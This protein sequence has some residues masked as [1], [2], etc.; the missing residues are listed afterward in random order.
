MREGAETVVECV[1]A[2][3]TSKRWCAGA[4][5]GFGYGPVVALPARH[6]LCA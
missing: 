5:S 6:A 3:G 1:S 4:V 2:V